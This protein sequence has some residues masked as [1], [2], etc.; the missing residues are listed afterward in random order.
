[1][2]AVRAGGALLVPVPAA[3][4][5][6]TTAGREWREGGSDVAGG[7]AGGGTWELP[8]AGG[9][10]MGRGA[11]PCAPCGVGSMGAGTPQLPMPGCMGAPAQ[12]PP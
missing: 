3:V 6:G 7:G 10:P 11:T 8:V 9:A 2:G 12:P 4:A 1:M 5:P